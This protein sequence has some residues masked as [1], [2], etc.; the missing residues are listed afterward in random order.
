MSEYEPATEDNVK[1]ILAKTVAYCERNGDM[2]YLAECV[3]AMLD[4]MLSM[5]AFG[6]EGQC[7]P[8]GDH[9]D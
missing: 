7:D 4:D 6:T 8:R 5:D 2:D 9:R 3:N 1:E